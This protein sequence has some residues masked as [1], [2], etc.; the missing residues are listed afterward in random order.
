MFWVQYHW[1]AKFTWL[2][3]HFE[4]LNGQLAIRVGRKTL[5]WRVQ[6]VDVS[7]VF[8]WH[9]NTV[10]ESWARSVRCK[11]G[12]KFVE[13]LE[14]LKGTRK[15]KFSIFFHF[16]GR[17]FR[18]DE[19]ISTLVSKLKSD[20]IWPS[21]WRKKLLKVKN[22][23]NG[24][25]CQIWTVFLAKKGVK[26]CIISILRSD[27]ESSRSGETFW[28]QNERKLNTFLAP[29]KHFQNFNEFAPIL[30]PYRSSSN[31]VYTVLVS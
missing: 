27:L 9:Q 23:Q 16:G 10:Y 7:K 20:N 24:Q 17:K 11:D 8:L 26:C 30:T 12:C 29:Q 22:W 4:A 28:S 13:A 25:F 6:G 19:N 18:L 1:M 31:F 3:D 5:Y 14:I 15:I 21:F 2:D